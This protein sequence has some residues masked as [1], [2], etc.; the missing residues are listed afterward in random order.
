MVRDSRVDLAK[1]WKRQIGKGSWQV[2]VNYVARKSKLNQSAR[3]SVWADLEY[4]GDREVIVRSGKSSDGFSLFCAGLSIFWPHLT[5]QE[6][7]VGPSI[8]LKE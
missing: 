4:K 7:S 8:Y 3:V 2:V 1:N 5:A 6:Q